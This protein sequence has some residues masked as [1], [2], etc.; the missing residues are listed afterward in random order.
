MVIH[1]GK[2]TM[3]RKLLAQLIFVI[4]LLIGI[5]VIPQLLVGSTPV[6]QLSKAQALGGEIAQAI[7]PDDNHHLLTPGKDLI[8]NSIK[9]FDGTTWAVASIHTANVSDEAL[10][11]LQQNS[12]TYTVVL[13]PGTSFAHS[14]LTKLPDDVSNYLVTKGAVYESN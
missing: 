12:G 13:G 8:I 14:D 9:Y 4:L 11:V 5:G 1:N 7:G 10:A 3:N 2:G 6:V